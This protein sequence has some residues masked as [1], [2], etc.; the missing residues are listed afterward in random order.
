MVPNSED[1]NELGPDMK[2]KFLVLFKEF[3]SRQKLR[4]VHE[5]T[6]YFGLVQSKAKFAT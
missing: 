2:K 3:Y 5:D 1:V 4:L 6:H